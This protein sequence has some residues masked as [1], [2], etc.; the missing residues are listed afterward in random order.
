MDCSERAQCS[1]TAIAKR[2]SFDAGHVMVHFLHTGTYQCLRPKGQSPQDKR[3]A[4]FTTNVR[5]FFHGPDLSPRY[6]S[7][8][9]NSR[10]LET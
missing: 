7:W 1:L 4:E 6:S 9:S 5:V 10:N 3:A 8:L 2:T